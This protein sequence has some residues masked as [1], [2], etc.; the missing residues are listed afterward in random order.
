MKNPQCL[1]VLLLEQNITKKKQVLKEQ[2]L[3][4]MLNN[5]KKYYIKVI[6]NCTVYANK[7]IGNLGGLY[8]LIS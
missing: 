6:Q 8:Y 2:Q 3:E 1:F 7:I 5:T 4:H